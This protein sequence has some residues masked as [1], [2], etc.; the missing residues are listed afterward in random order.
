MEKIEKKNIIIICSKLIIMYI[1]IIYL[2]HSLTC[3]LYIFSIIIVYLL[4][5][6]V[7]IQKVRDL[8]ASSIEKEIPTTPALKEL[9]MKSDAFM[10]IYF[11]RNINCYSIYN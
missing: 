4:H 8:K 5:F 2:L 6:F 11:Y 10:I 1:K 7:D 9:H 3:L